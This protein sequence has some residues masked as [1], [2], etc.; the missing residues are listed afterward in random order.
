MSQQNFRNASVSTSHFTMVPRAGVPRSTFAIEHT[1]K[2]AFDAGLVVPIYLQEALPGDHFQVDMTA[3]CRMATPL[4]PVM[5][6][7][8]LDSFFFF[9]PNRLVWA[10][11]NRFMGERPNPDD[12]IDFLVPRMKFN[13]TTPPTVGSVWDYFGIPTAGQ[14]TDAVNFSFNALPYRGYKLIWNEWFRDQNLQTRVSNPVTDGPDNVSP[15]VKPLTRNKRHDYFTS[16][17]PWPQK[18]D[19]VTLPLAGVAPVR[20]IGVEDVARAA[21][22]KTFYESGAPYEATAAYW[23][24]NGTPSGQAIVVAQ[25]ADSIPQIFADLS[26]ATGATIN[27]LRQSMAVQQLLERDARGGTRYV[28]ILLSH[29]GVQPQDARLQRP[30]YIGGGSTPVNI[31]PI[32]QQSA[33]TPTAPLGA[34]AGISTALNRNGFSYAVQEHGFIFGIVSVRADLTYQQGLNRMWSRST[35]YDYYWPEFAHL[36]EQ[37]ILRKEIYCVGNPAVDDLVFG[38]Q[39]RWS[40][41]RYHPSMIT[42]IMRST[43]AGNIDEWHLAQQFSTPPTLSDT[44]IREAPPMARVLA[45][46]EL[47]NGQQFIC[48]AL[49]RSRVTRPMPTYSVPGLG[50]RF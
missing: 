9:V 39:E 11:W 40:E 29:F 30:E 6:N 19:A 22:P 49:F 1:H 44:F 35:R 50:D 4:F 45:A 43:A 48:D 38:Y 28:E 23:S 17:L 12:S 3:F 2:T 24:T 27:A 41:Y 26:Q 15:T 46:G 13:P 37:A 14:L 21:G 10:N 36:G 31:N 20:G 5:D 25:N 32:A 34:L 8:H 7:L 42:G 16:A 47:A 18:G 33:G